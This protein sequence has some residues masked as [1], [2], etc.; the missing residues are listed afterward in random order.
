MNS[1]NL[2]TVRQILASAKTIAV[3]GLSANE[4]KDSNRV[5]KYLQGKGYKVIPVNPAATEILGEKS[6]PDLTSIPDKIDIVDVFRKPEFLND[7]AEQAVK[8]GAKTLWMQQGIRNDAAAQT[9][10]G[11]GLEALQDICIMQAHKQ[12]MV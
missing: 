10:R 4:S 8:I 2:D 5:A 9:A 3:V 12:L 6:Y 1:N 11:G 7:I